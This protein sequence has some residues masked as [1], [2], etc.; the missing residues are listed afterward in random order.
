MLTAC[1]TLYAKSI[2]PWWLPIP[3]GGVFAAMTFPILIIRWHRITGS[4]NRILNVASHTVTMGLIGA[5]LFL[6]LNYFCTDQSSFKSVQATVSNKYRKEH[7][8]R[9]RVG[10]NRY[11][12]DGHWYSY[13][14]C[15]T[16][17]DNVTK[18][19]EVPLS[20]YNNTKI[21]TTRTLQLENGL[22][23]FTIIK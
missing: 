23:G 16:L 1:F 11:I 20:E 12:P 15:L 22:F 5:S 13:R 8:R 18:E 19:I 4:S 9:R 17:P 3:I 14:L 6:S 10:R 21:G 7:E 2:M